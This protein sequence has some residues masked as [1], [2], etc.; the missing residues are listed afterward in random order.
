MSLPGTAAPRCSS[1]TELWRFPELRRLGVGSTRAAELARGGRLGPRCENAAVASIWC[2]RHCLLHVHYSLA[3]SR[4]VPAPAEAPVHTELI[5]LAALSDGPGDDAMSDHSLAS[6]AVAL[7]S[8]YLLG[9]YAA[10]QCPRRLELDCD[11][12]APVERR[13][14]PPLEAMRRMEEG[15]R[16]EAEI[17]EHLRAAFPGDEAVFLDGDR[18]PESLAQRAE[19]TA[20]AMEGGVRLIWNPRL[21]PHPE[22]ARTGEPDV[23]VRVGE[24]GPATDRWHYLPVDVKNHQA[25]GGA[26]APREWCCS[27]LEAPWPEAAERMELEGTPLL[28]DSMQLAHYYRMLQTAGAAAY[29]TGGIIGKAVGGRL[30]IVWRDLDEPVHPETAEDGGRAKRSALEIYDRE[31]ANRLAIARRV[32]ERQERPGLPRLARTEWKAE[33]GECPWRV[34]CHEEL[35]ANEHITLLPGITAGRAR[36]HYAVG[37]ERIGQLAALDRRTA[38]LVDA[39]VDV[40]AFLGVAT[41]LDLDAGVAELVEGRVL[42][43]G[44]KPK[45]AAALAAADIRVVRDLAGLDPATARYAGTGVVNLSAAIDQARVTKSGRV[46][47]ARGVAAVHLPRAAVEVDLDME[48]DDL[49][50][51]W[52]ALVTFTD[53]DGTRSEINRPFVS[54]SGKEEDEGRVFA[55][56]WGAINSLRV[57]S[58]GGGFKLY[59][60]TQAEISMLRK[61]AAKH[62]GG[63]GVPSEDEV[64]SFIASGEIVDLYEVVSKQLVWPTENLSIKSVAKYCG[65]A[66]RDAEAG[67]GNSVSWYRA[68]VA[69]ESAEIRTVNANRVTDYNADDN[70]ANRMVREYLRNAQASGELPSIE[71]LEPEHV[72]A[73]VLA[74]K[75]G[76]STSSPAEAGG[77]RRGPS[78]Q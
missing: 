24:P 22:T 31:Y 1:L 36:A 57:M 38:R 37:V 4:V 2:G 66:W 46:H 59:H 60:Y 47:R 12:N 20:A 8:G 14:P 55:E 76:A 39:K 21:R 42:R 43:G 45:V 35:A 69:G 10:K 30:A 56:L 41:T 72:L 67:G 48:N 49:T 19:A 27:P 63:R 58:D 62:A 29:P 40:P 6:A 26:A 9:G 64:E 65:F 34:V 15:N 16:F 17:A 61:L 44:T 74:N 51:L 68:A 23:L 75:W 70:Y 53:P 5:E 25:F 54:F 77:G 28:S 33:C 52:G 18:S 11:P 13:A 3:G 32:D 78:L 7:K 71:D 50:Y 73:S